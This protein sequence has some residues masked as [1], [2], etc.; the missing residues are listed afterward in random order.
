MNP[1]IFFKSNGGKIGDPFN[2]ALGWLAV[3]SVP[4]HHDGVTRLLSI[5]CH[6]MEDIEANANKLKQLIDDAVRK[7]RKKLPKC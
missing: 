5:P 6:D 3:G 4:L 7:A 1:K 2:P